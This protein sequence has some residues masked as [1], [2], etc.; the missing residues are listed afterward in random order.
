MI[1]SMQKTNNN[2]FMCKRNQNITSVQDRDFVN[3]A[4]PS[5]NIHYEPKF[6]FG[7]IFDSSNFCS[8][9]IIMFVSAFLTSRCYRKAIE[10]F[11]D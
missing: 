3:W 5:A 7:I 9:E 4:G 2:N 1:Y 8:T 10:S 11:A 6:S